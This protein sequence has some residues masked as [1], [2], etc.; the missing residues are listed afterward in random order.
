MSSRKHKRP[1]FPQAAG[2]DQSGFWLTRTLQQTEILLLA[3]LGF[4]FCL[5]S[6]YHLDVPAGKLVWS[7][8]VF[9]ALFLVVFSSRRRKLLL[10][11]CLLATVLWTWRNA[12]SLSQG[13]LLLVD[14]ALDPLGLRLPDVLQNVLQ[15][16]SAEEAGML[17]LLALRAL[18]FV[19]TLF[20][21]YFIV[22]R[23]STIGLA[24]S[25]LPLLLPAPFYL[26]AP[27]IAPFF[28]LAAAL[29]M[30]YI[31]NSAS[32]MPSRILQ[33]NLEEAP[34]ALRRPLFDQKQAQQMLALFALPVIVLAALF[35][36]WIL[37]QDGYQR[38]ES[39]EAL[40]DKIF[41]LKFGEET[42]Q[43]SNDGLTHGDFR[44]LSD[45][46]FSGET[47]IQVRAS[48]QQVYYLRDY[49]GA[50]YT[51]HGWENVSSHVYEKYAENFLDIAPQNLLAAAAAASQSA[52]ETYSLSIKYV[53]AARTSM[54][55]PCGL[56]TNADEIP[57]ASFLQDTAMQYAAASGA[58]YT[59]KAL[60][61]S[62]V[63]STVD[64]GGADET[65]G[66]LRSAYTAA[67][68]SAV[69]LS[70][71]DD[72]PAQQTLSA[73][74]AYID[75]IFETYTAL[76]DDTR[77]SAEQICNAE[78]LSLSFE[79]DALNLYDT[80]LDLHRY[81]TNQCA[82]S[83]SPPE[84]PSG[85]D[86]AI[87]FLE[88]SRLGYCVHFASAATVLLRSLGIPARYAEGYIIVGSD[89]DKQPDDEGYID[90]E[91]THA[92]AWVE[93]FDPVQLE[94]IPVE[95][96]ASAIRSADA[97]PN[98]EEENADTPAPS[99][100]PSPEPTVAPTPEPTVTPEAE[101]S[102]NPDASASPDDE[103]TPEETPSAESG[104]TQDTAR[105]TPTPAPG[106]EDP[107]ETDSSATGGNDGDTGADEAAT[108][109]LSLWP[110]LII[111]GVAIAILGAFGWRTALQARRRRLFLQRDA[112][113]AILA[114]C[115]YVLDMLRFAGCEPMQPSQ[116]PE[117]Y[118][119]IAAKRLAWVDRDQLETLLELAQRARFS[120]KTASRQ[121]R[122]AAASFAAAL[123]ADL[124]TRLPRL[125]RWL[126]CWLY[127]PV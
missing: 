42:S 23:P 110:L 78:G 122:G 121:E 65:A 68:G 126:F 58:D 17:T 12:Q 115:R 108:S 89:Y 98:P 94:W 34:P 44:V 123:A 49:A 52:S 112:N 50:T 83:Y 45:I 62:T 18:L 107:S 6:S 20:S 120:G 69:N 72:S 55:T 33:T 80:C 35:S 39:I 26:L 106:G 5:T 61:C 66:A 76:P 11:V 10:L 79:G 31:L 21:A 70:G 116:L 81:L 36:S 2:D 75:Y 32:N 24:V 9:C 111:L 100:T 87:Y 56:V 109:R 27:G 67:A 97:T 59:I 30:Q 53:S 64:L 63:L 117:D 118:A 95:M 103:G 16:Y 127:P 105:Q 1:L 92:H 125:R 77:L 3:I 124:R 101:A 8:L 84:I 114:I 57:G 71:A 86:F 22:R 73:A 40:Q 91:D 37:P 113:A 43:K 48:K 29:L 99:E 74:Q 47:A 104:D 119:Y 90:I 46:R 13:L 14:Q 54:W 85:A 19:V 82:Y 41:S 25:T 88:Q 4:L 102:E 93:V 15:A 60:P 28:C 51:Q 96:T 38:P 7:A